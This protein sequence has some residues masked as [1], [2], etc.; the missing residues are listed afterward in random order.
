MQYL[1]LTHGADYPALLTYPDN[2]RILEAARDSGLLTSDQ[3]R[4]LTDAYLGLRSALH[5]FA[6]AQHDVTDAS[7]ELDA[8]QQAVSHVWDT[9]FS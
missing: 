6:L 7:D 1:V 4:Q 5:H 8:H 3:F 9:V 2:V